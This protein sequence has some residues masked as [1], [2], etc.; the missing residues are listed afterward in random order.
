MA[1][2]LL[3]FSS[4]RRHTRCALVT[5]V[6][7]C[8][9]QI[10]KEN[11]WQGRNITRWQNEDYDKLYREG[12]AELDPVKRGAMFIKMNELVIEHV[13]VIPVM[14]RGSVAAVSGKLSAPLS[15][16]D[17]N[18]WNLKDWYREA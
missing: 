1:G 10:S 4:R 3:F 17:N 9:L 2:R 14:W 11:K 13:V 18:T 7:T 6:Q 16:W 5:G 12:E 15:A 8:A